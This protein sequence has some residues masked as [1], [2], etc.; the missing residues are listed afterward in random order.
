MFDFMFAMSYVRIASYF[1]KISVCMWSK[2]E[3]E[4]VE[5]QVFCTIVPKPVSVSNTQFGS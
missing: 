3:P 4:S 1:L 5:N 2:Y